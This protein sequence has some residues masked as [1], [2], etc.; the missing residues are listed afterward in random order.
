MVSPTTK[1]KHGV[2]KEV[3]KAYVLRDTKTDLGI[4]ISEL[5]SFNDD[6]IVTQVK[7]QK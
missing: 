4:E 5:I 2:T 1:I 3:T 7:L 6:K